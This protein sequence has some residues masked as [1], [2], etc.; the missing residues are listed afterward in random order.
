MRF[1]RY[2]PRVHHMHSILRII[3]KNIRIPP[4]VVGRHSKYG[5]FVKKNV[6]RVKLNSVFSG[7]SS[8]TLIFSI[9]RIIIKSP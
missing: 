4:F 1:L 3:F 6:F 8:V 2:N 7:L 5:L 9:A